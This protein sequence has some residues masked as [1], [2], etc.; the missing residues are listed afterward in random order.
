MRYSKKRLLNVSS[1]WNNW[2]LL[3]PPLLNK[4]WETSTSNIEVTIIFKKLRVSAYYP[5]FVRFLCS[6]HNWH[7]C[8]WHLPRGKKLPDTAPRQPGHSVTR[9]IS[10]P[11]RDKGTGETGPRQEHCKLASTT[12]DLITTLITRDILIEEVL[13]P[14]PVLVLFCFQS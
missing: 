9:H 11:L 4:D 13:V 2:L 14:P 8:I 1:Y 10:P 3:W 6:A 7:W 5:H 12:A